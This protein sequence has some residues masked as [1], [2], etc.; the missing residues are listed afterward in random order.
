MT[1]LRTLLAATDL[2]APATRAVERA[3]ELARRRH[4]AL[5]VLHALDLSAIERLQAWEGLDGAGLAQ[6]LLDEAQDALTREVGS[7]GEKWGLSAQAVV[8]AGAV[9]PTISTQADRVDADLVIAGA[10]G[11][12]VFGRLL[13]GTT[14]ERLLRR[15]RRPLLVVRREV[16][17]PYDRVLVPMDFSPWSAAALALARAVVP[18]AT[19][20]LLHA[21]EAPFESKLRYA[22]VDG[23]QIDAYLATARDEAWRALRTL[24]R[25]AQSDPDAAPGEA[26]GITIDCVVKHGA[27]G[28]VIEAEAERLGCDLIVVGKHGRGVLEDMLLGSV[29][30]HVLAES[31]VDVL[32]ATT[33]ETGAQTT[34]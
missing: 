15:T 9:L 31:D 10:R 14:V 34:Q 27:P 33:P 29:T 32:V 2:S 12:G 21:F 28:A 24:A 7:L 23:A 8:A 16:T 5:T 19:L 4:A 11:A 17:G 30:K 26:Q 13:V 25:A 6:R 3:F 18:D 22:G 1:S 20:T